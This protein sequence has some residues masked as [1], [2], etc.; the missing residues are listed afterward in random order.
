MDIGISFTERGW[1]FTILKELVRDSIRF[2]GQQPLGRMCPSR[3]QGQ[4]LLLM[5]EGFFI[6]ELHYLPLTDGRPVSQQM[7]G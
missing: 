2:D 4:F 7:F 5:P 6:L 3:G 1:I